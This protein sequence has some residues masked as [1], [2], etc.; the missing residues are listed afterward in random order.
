MAGE[1]DPEWPREPLTDEKREEM[2]TLMTAGLM[3]IH[4][5]FEPHRR[6]MA[7]ANCEG[8]YLSATRAENRS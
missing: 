2:L 6:D 4:R 3:G 1:V 7:R 5:Y 8:A